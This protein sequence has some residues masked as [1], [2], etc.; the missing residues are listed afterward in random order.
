MAIQK[1][2]FP[3]VFAGLRDTRFTVENFK[4]T[5]EFAG[6][7]IVNDLL[8]DKSGLTQGV[9]FWDMIITSENLSKL[10]VRFEAYLQGW[11]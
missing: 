10:I 7:Q 9:L 1:R 3:V 2:Y 5:S 4:S 11:F 6:L 8:L